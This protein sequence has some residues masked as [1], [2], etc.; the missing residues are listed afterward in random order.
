VNDTPVMVVLPDCSTGIATIR[1]GQTAV[2]PVV[3]DLAG[4]CTVDNAVRGNVVG[5]I[6]M[7]RPIGDDLVVQ[8]SRAHACS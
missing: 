5:C 2:L 6:T 1:A 8:L 7:P 4:E 3:S